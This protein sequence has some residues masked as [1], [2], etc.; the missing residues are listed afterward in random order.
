MR[1]R[2]FPV[3]GDISPNRGSEY[4]IN[5]LLQPAACMISHLQPLARLSLSFMSLTS[6]LPSILLSGFVSSASPQV[7][8]LWFSPTSNST[9]ASGGL[10]RSLE[11]IASVFLGADLIVQPSK[12]CNN[13]A[14]IL[15]ENRFI[16]QFVSLMPYFCPKIILCMSKYTMKRFSFERL[17][18]LKANDSRY[19]QMKTHTR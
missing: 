17:N 4:R 11:V 8:Q 3:D 14:T 2:L 12:Q 6:F 10:P 13:I 19:V 5:Y 18:V 9:S 16:V 1:P 15:N 7:S